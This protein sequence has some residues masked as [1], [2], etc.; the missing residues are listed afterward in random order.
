MKQQH[1]NAGGRETEIFRISKIHLCAYILGPEL[2]PASDFV[3]GIGGKAFKG[4]E[5]VLGQLYRSIEWMR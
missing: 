1:Q 3:A 5:V 2:C 4:G